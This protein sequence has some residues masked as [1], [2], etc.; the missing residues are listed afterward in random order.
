MVGTVMWL[1]PKI[2]HVFVTVTRSGGRMVH[3]VVISTKSLSVM[4]ENFQ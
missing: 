1:T 4:S 3:Y 2:S